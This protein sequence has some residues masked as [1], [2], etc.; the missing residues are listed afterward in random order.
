MSMSN[1][2][3]RNDY[4]NSTSWKST[5][6]WLYNTKK[7]RSNNRKHGTTA[8]SRT[9]TYRSVTLHY[10]TVV[11]SKENLKNS[12]QNGWDLTL[13]KRYIPTDQSD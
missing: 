12:T 1:L 9:K 13:S 10:S 11:E 7:S 3:R 8:T 5:D 4:F 6:S 2:E